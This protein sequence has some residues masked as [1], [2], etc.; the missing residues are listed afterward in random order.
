MRTKITALIIVSLLVSVGC[1]AK[2]TGTLAN[3]YSAAE[4]CEAVKNFTWTSN[5]DYESTGEVYVK[6]IISRIANSGTFTESGMFGNASFFI[7]DKVGDQ[8]FYC[9]R[10]LYLGNQMFEQGQT[11]IKVGDEV[12]VC[13]KLMNYHE[14]TPQTV[15][16]NA[17]LYSL[18]GIIN[19]GTLAHP[20][21]AAEACAAV[22]NLTWT[23]NAD[24]ESTGEVYVK[25]IISR[26][27]SRGTYSEGG[28][29]GNASFFIKDKGGDQ[30]FYCFR[31]YYLGNQPYQE[32]QGDIKEGDEVIICGKLMNYQG[33]T[34][35]TVAAKAYLYSIDR[36]S[37]RGTLTNPYSVAAACKAV[38]NLFWMT[39]SA[40]ESTDEVYVKGIISRIVKLGTFAHG[41]S[42]GTAMFYIKDEVGDKE[43]YCFNILYLDNQ[44]YQ[45]GQGDIK[46]GDEVIICGKLMNYRGNTPATVPNKAYLYSIDR[47][48]SRG[49]LAKP[50]S[51][52]QACRAVEHLT[53]TS[54]ADYESTDEVFVKGTISRIAN[55][56]TFTETGMF[57]NASFFIK[58]KVGDQEFY[59]YRILYLGN[60][61]FEQG[62]TDI[63]V[64]DEVIVCGKLM[65]YHENTPQTVSN[66]A[67]LYSLNG[68]NGGYSFIATDLHQVTSDKSQVQSN[69]WYTIDGQKL[70]GMPVKKGVYIQN[71]KK[72]S[73]P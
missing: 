21:S 15:S 4:A 71:G 43:F 68:D 72:R 18:N 55:S 59:C 35:E 64:G 61:M 63:K 28:S 51:V 16:N 58:D 56:S 24:Y 53:W 29:Y 8:E 9:Y 60:Q 48:N 45:E 6:G 62:Q 57:G 46:V 20:Y 22:K 44:P 27:A 31:V 41:G 65:N 7:K 73:H 47:T 1:F 40:Y 23:S 69:E 66:N 10:I 37:G 13:G 30:E 3:P 17:F 52:A 34:P 32:W 19:S 25:G 36:I 49:T 26:I 54:N 70:N 39:N 2:G 5:A 11:D 42:H 50:Y 38:K 12:I 14:N 33:N 67:F